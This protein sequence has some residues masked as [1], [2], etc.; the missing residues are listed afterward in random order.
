MS[1]CLRYWGYC[2][3]NLRYFFIDLVLK[4]GTIESEPFNKDLRMILIEWVFDSLI[5][6]ILF[7]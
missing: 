3:S 4:H 5:K 2:L 1:E 7:F 6:L